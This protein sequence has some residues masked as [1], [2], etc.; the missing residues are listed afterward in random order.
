ML[1]VHLDFTR[2]MARDLVAALADPLPKHLFEKCLDPD[3]VLP[4]KWDR[5]RAVVFSLSKVI[6]E[7]RRDDEM[8]QLQ[9]LAGQKAFYWDPA[10]F[11]QPTHLH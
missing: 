2:Q 9:S 8:K 5:Y 3:T 7:Q 11:D 1:R 10:E 6:I 4:P